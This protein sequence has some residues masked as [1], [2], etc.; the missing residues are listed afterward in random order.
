MNYEEITVKR[1]AVEVISDHNA[2]CEYWFPGRNG[3]EELP[4]VME[5]KDMLRY[6]EQRLV[7]RPVSI[8]IAI[9]YE[10]P[11]VIGKQLIRRTPHR[12]DKREALETL[13]RQVL[14]DCVEDAKAEAKKEPA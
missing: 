2:P 14:G 10:A 6:A 4:D 1:I 8:G 12:I 13:M 3:S 9:I 11:S 5:L 7:G